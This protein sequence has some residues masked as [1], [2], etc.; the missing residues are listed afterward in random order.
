MDHAQSLFDDFE[1]QGYWWLPE[2][3]D[4]KVAGH[5][6]RKNQEIRLEL[7]GDLMQLS[8]EERGIVKQP[9][10]PPFILGNVEGLGYCTLY[11]TTEVGSTLRTS[12]FVATRFTAQML[13]TGAHASSEDDLS[14]AT[15]S[16]SYTNIEEWMCWHPFRRAMPQFANDVVQAEASYRSFPV[17]RFELP[18]LNAA[19]SLEPLFSSA[20]SVR[21]LNWEHTASL[22]IELTGDRSLQRYLALMSDCRNLLTLFVGQP[23]WAKTIVAEGDEIEMAAGYRT[24]PQVRLY[25][26][27]GRDAKPEE[28][29]FADMLVTYPALHDRFGA[30]LS[31]WLTKAAELRTVT[32][33]YFATI[34]HKATFLRF[35][36][37]SLAQ[38]LECYARLRHDPNE[39]ESDLKKLLEPVLASLSADAVK[40]VT[41]DQDRFL[42]HLRTTRNYFTHYLRKYELDALQDVELF[43]FNE[44]LRLLLTILL[45]KEAGLDEPLVVRLI[46]G[47]HRIMVWRHLYPDGPLPAV[48]PPAPPHAG[49]SG[50]EGA[51]SGRLQP[52]LI[53]ETLEEVDRQARGEEVSPQT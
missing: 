24:R 32:D 31:S 23:I 50:V 39:R 37:L 48:E 13:L 53:D 27:Q 9:P 12:G 33:L 47:N 7:L 36:F 21:S 4:S 28:V 6:S 51:L 34:Y 43:K 11:K 15:V 22:Q 44:R 16:A 40:L 8:F 52:E 46:A 3:P 20:G 41:S 35:Q 18:T 42:N 30:V 19:V 49:E 45:L 5:L 26:S 29:S 25:F 17:T 1:S 2:R 10:R 14:F 38:A